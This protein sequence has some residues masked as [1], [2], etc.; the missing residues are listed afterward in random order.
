LAR[1]PKIFYTERK[2][3]IHISCG[4]IYCL[5]QQETTGDYFSIKPPLLVEDPERFYRSGGKVK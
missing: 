3:R 4:A 5:V 1:N 2:A